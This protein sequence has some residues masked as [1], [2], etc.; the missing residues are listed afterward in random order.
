MSDLFS[1]G[2]QELLAR[3]GLTPESRARVDSALRLI[4][5]LDFEVELFAKLVANR[6]RTDRGYLAIQ[7]LPGVGPL[8]AA[9]FVAEI[10]DV[11]RFARPAQLASWAG[12]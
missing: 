5:G 7:Q 3:V 6:P 11:G 8:L 12:R 1:P 9:V 2:G 10:G 4:T